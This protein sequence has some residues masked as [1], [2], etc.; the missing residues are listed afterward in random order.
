MNQRTARNG[1]LAI[2]A[3]LALACVPAPE[4]S[5]PAE[6]TMPPTSTRPPTSMPT[7][8]P[9]STHTPIPT[10]TL[11]PSP[12]ATPTI[13]PMLS[14]ARAFAEPILASIA[15]RP[16][17]FADDFED[18]SGGWSTGMQYEAESGGERGDTGYA[19]GEYFMVANPAHSPANGPELTCNNGHA[20]SM[21][22]V[23]GF[24]M[25][26]DGRFASGAGP[27]SWQL[28]FGRRAEPKGER[29][30]EYNAMVQVDG[31]MNLV[32]FTYAPDAHTDLARRRGWPVNSGAAANHVLFIFQDAELAVYINDQ[33]YLYARDADFQAHLLGEI[34][35]G[36]CNSGDEPLRSQWDNI[37]VWALPAPP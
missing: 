28:Q 24:V 17:D 8:T 20:S 33:P 3:V 14:Q 32:K 4:P 27:G 5:P 30:E 22:L 6:A 11:T 23:S 21:P 26:I 12:T 35:L 13:D 2:I 31:S 1:I 7:L 16:P 9:T 29:L 18:T 25:E 15:D 19:D 37:K 34:S 36:L 10:S